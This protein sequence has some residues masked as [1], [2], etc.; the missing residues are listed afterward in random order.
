[1]TDFAFIRALVHA[2]RWSTARAEAASDPIALEY[3][4]AHAARAGVAPTLP[5]FEDTCRGDGAGDRVGQPSFDPRNEDGD[6]PSLRG[7]RGDGSGD[8]DG[9]P[10]GDGDRAGWSDGNGAGVGEYEPWDASDAQDR[11]MWE[12]GGTP[13]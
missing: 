10:T 13:A 11:W 5:V 6:L 2:R 9:E 3:V 7:F 8:C 12:L 4:R 1:M